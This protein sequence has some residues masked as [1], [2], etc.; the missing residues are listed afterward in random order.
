MKKLFI[1]TSIGFAL[2]ACGGSTDSTQSTES[3]SAATTQESTA[4][5]ENPSYDPKRGE[6]KFDHVELGASLDAAMATKGEEVSGV[7][8]S[9]CHKT[10]SEKVVGPGWEGVT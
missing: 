3:S 9:S 6:G 1:L 2:A 4:S 7:K 5:T 10:T 8:C